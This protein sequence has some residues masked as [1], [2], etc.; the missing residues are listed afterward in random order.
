LDS[1]YLTFAILF[2]VFGIVGVSATA[3]VSPNFLSIAT[4]NCSPPIQARIQ[5][6][7]LVVLAVGLVMAPIGILKRGA[8]MSATSVPEGPFPSGR[9]YTGP[10]V[11]SGEFLAL[12]IF[13]VVL[14][15]A[16]IAP[17]YLVLK[18]WILIGEGVDVVA[19]GIYL[20]L[21]GGRPK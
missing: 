11:A 3:A 7:S 6:L 5:E 16:T 1:D 21:R 13:L 20:V 9:T 14:G 18:N 2:G 4:C 15:V 8:P 19:L 17:S 10:V 12:G